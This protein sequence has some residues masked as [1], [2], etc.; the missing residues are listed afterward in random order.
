MV[1]FLIN[2]MSVWIFSK[3][4]NKGVDDHGSGCSLPT[5]VKQAYYLGGDASGLTYRVSK[6]HLQNK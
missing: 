6:E 1:V 4:Y 3:D 2:G 5:Q